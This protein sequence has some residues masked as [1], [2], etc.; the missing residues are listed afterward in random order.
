MLKV[1]QDV[2][3]EHLKAMKRSLRIVLP[4]QLKLFVLKAPYHELEFIT[5]RQNQVSRSHLLDLINLMPVDRKSRVDLLEVVHIDENNHAGFKAC[6][7]VVVVAVKRFLPRNF[8]QNIKPLLCWR[9]VHIGFEITNLSIV[10]ICG[11]L[12]YLAILPQLME[13]AE[14]LTVEDRWLD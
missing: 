7:E 3:T 12:K 5:E 14:N 6:N 9:T 8:I 2:F 10:G 11:L 4:V 13:L 1:E